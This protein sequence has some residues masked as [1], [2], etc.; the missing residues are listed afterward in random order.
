MFIFFD[1]SDDIWLHPDILQGFRSEPLV[2]D[3]SFFSAWAWLELPVILHEKK[4]DFF[5]DNRCSF[6]VCR[7]K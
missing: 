7:S 3:E 1:E 5:V 4:R 2:P 6:E